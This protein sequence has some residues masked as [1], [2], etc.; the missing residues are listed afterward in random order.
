MANSRNE[1]LLE[2]ILGGSNEYGEP[3]SRNEAILQNILGEHNVIA[4]PTSRIEELLIQILEQGT[5]GGNIGYQVT[6]TVDGEPYYVASCLEGESITEPPT[7]TI[8]G[9]IFGGWKL[10][11]TIITFPYT[12][13]K[14]VELTAYLP[15]KNYLAGNNDNIVTLRG[16][17]FA[18]KNLV[19]GNGFAGNK[20]LVGYNYGSDGKTGVILVTKASR[21]NAIERSPSTLT[22]NATNA[23][24]YNGETYYYARLS[25]FASVETD[26]SGLNRYQCTNGLTD[27]Q[28]ATEL[29][30][31]YFAD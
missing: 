30:D 7:P 17:S 8:E 22:A 25:P 6:F 5:G 9:K 29:L 19:D 21:N 31:A 11:D 4:E 15:S 10:N 1:D 16:F 24:I 2:N 12:P 27:E 23:I 28:A 26:T 14:D 13:S 20:D 18:V 3:Q